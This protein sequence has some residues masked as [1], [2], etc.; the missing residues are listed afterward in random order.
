MQADD[1]P[2]D[3]RPDAD[4]W[5]QRLA[6]VL[7][8]MREVS[9]QTDPQALVRTYSQRIRRILPTDR[10]V[11][12]SRRGLEAPWFRV[13]RFSG[14][15]D[16]VNPWA[17]P[18][19]LPQHQG[20]LLAD[21][22]YRDAAC[23]LDDPVLAPDDPARPYLEGMRSF[24][25]LPN[26]D[27][28]QALNMTILMRQD[29]GGFRPEML[30]DRV[31][32]SN[33]FGRATQ[34]LVLAEELRRAYEL[35][36]HELHQVAAIQRSL[37]PQAIPKIERLDLAVHYQ[38]SRWAGGDYYDFFPLANGAYGLLVADVSGHGTPAAVIMAITHSLAHS[39]P[40]HHMPPGSLLSH[41]NRRL[42]Q[43]YT[44]DSG[45][46]VTAF[47]GIF[48]PKQRTLTYACAGHNPPRLKRCRTGA[49]RALD[50]VGGLPLGLFEEVQFDEATLR[51]I[52]GDQLVLYT[53]GIT[54]AT[55]PDGAQF[56]TERLDGSIGGC[57]A[58]ADGL[59][60]GILA[61]LERFTAGQPP[62]DDQTLLVARVS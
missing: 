8:M 58:T 56:G 43:S 26:F 5:Q 12:I 25:V 50:A 2:G 13:T 4:T 49:V 39:N 7:D 61:D 41:V 9:L 45:T 24:A 62:A 17:T 31:W 57:L 42:V 22:L 11:S 10:S 34:T 54:E 59:I 15:R 19:R 47:Y 21:L 48:D 38:T 36:D 29:P 28:G 23:V 30:P 53:D 20:G 37:L 35:V 46:F 55:A 60:A 18:E 1:G 3:A 14:W 27:R 32:M 33:L 16:E 6:E 52:P 40:D 51:L 44:E